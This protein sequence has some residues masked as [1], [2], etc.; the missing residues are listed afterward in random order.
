MTR[1]EFIK[2]SSAL[3]IGFPFI[4][5]LL[6]A[7]SK[8][9]VFMNAFDVNFSGK[10]LIIGAGAAGLTAG[11]IL[12]KHNIDF[13]I[14]E[15]SSVFGGRVKR[16]DNFADFPIDLGGEWIHTEPSIFAK[17]LNEPAT[18]G[19]IELIRYSPDSIYTWH[20]NKLSSHNWA[21]NFYGEYKFKNST[22]YG[23]FEKY[24]VP[25]IRD[26]IIYNTPVNEIDYSADKVFVKSINNDTFEADKI[27]VT[28]PVSILKSNAI[29]FLPNLPPEK[30]NALNNVYMPDILKV[31]IE[32]SEDFYPDIL[33]FG[34]L[35]DSDSQDKIFYDAAFRKD[36]NRNIL[37]LFVIGDQASVY[38]N[39]DSEEEII[40]TII[41]ELD[42]IFDGKASAKYIKHIIQDWTK[43]PY[44][45]GSY[46]HFDGSESE[47]IEILSQPVD[48]K[49]YFAGEAYA[50]D[51]ATVHGAG[52]SAYSAVETILNG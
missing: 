37:G 34:G 1:R 43:E 16:I 36:S 42:E 46:A 17:L 30:M 28:V 50:A 2:N 15:A 11:H 3:G 29:R 4:S 27:L 26:K 19:N 21:S 33:L 25:N 6:D 41:A 39:M 13:E 7:C 12:N 47:T 48:N 44:I 52:E 5:L 35:F 10:V 38:A 40:N 32:F 23:F 9:D 24:I 22:W 8:D 20:N 51:T 14:I 49:L 18:N 45:Q 31:F